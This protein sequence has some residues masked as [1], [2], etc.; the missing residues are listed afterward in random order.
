MQP[1][2]LRTQ[3]QHIAKHCHTALILAARGEPEGRE[4]RPHGGGI[5]IIGLIDQGDAAIG[6][7]DDEA[8]PTSSLGVEAVFAALR[9]HEIVVLGER[10]ELHHRPVPSSLVGRTLANSAI[11]TRTGMNVIAIH[12]EGEYLP[13]PNMDAPLSAN[14]QLVMVGSSDGME[15]FR[16]EFG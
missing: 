5:G 3:F 1:G 7:F 13:T 10:I 9:G 12:S 11:A 8:L 2:A 4:R 15:A 16:R 6:A 14:A